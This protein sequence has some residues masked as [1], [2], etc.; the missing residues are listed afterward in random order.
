[1]DKYAHDSLHGGYFENIGPDG[2]AAT[3][4]S[5][6]AVGAKED[7]KSMNTSIHILEAL[8][9]L[10]AVWPDPSSKKASG[11]ARYLPTEVLLSPVI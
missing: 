5:G 9:E 11:D 1:M 10:Y 4:K 3:P 6:N 2:K 7:Q 8:T